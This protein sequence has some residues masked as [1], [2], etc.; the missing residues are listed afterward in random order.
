[1][2]RRPE[3][4]VGGKGGSGKDSGKI[5]DEGNRKMLN[6]HLLDQ[7][8]SSSGSATDEEQGQSRVGRIQISPLLRYLEQE[9]DWC[10]HHPE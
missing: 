9:I 8:R 2:G 1:L 7:S 4:E 6:Q 10:R 3:D 5:V